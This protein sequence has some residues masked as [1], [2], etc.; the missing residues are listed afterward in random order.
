MTIHHLQKPVSQQGRS[1]RIRLL[2]YLS[3]F[4]TPI[5]ICTPGLQP[6]TYQ[7]DL[8]LSPVA[9]MSPDGTTMATY[10]WVDDVGIVADPV[11]PETYAQNVKAIDNFATL[12]VPGSSLRFKACGYYYQLITGLLLYF[13]E[14]APVVLH[15]T[16]PD[17]RS[18]DCHLE[19]L[20]ACTNR[21]CQS[22]DVK[23]KLQSVGRCTS[24]YSHP[25]WPGAY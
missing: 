14:T 18:R 7:P 24:L 21:T 19:A 16:A 13:K 22:H 25:A 17:G 9:K 12:G 20:T 3:E 11:I 5:G 10:G 2:G 1:T 15:A 23:I 6:C 8:Q 4:A